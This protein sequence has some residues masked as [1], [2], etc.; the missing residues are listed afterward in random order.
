MKMEAE[1]GEQSGN[2]GYARRSRLLDPL[3]KGESVRTTRAEPGC[4]GYHQS[5]RKRMQGVMVFREP[6][7]WMAGVAG[8]EFRDGAEAV[9]IGSDSG[10]DDG[11]FFATA[12]PGRRRQEPSGK[13][14]GYGAHGQRT[15]LSVSAC[16]G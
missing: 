11:G 16:T 5:E 4:G 14:V 13:K 3:A 12:E 15:W 1:E 2:P 10:E 9:E 6:E 8:E 7:Q